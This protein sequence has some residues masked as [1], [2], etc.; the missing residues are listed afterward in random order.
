M[1]TNED[2]EEFYTGHYGL[3]RSIVR[4]YVRNDDID[5]CV[6]EAMLRTWK[7]YHT[8]Q[9]KRKI[10][11][12]AYSIFRNTAINYAKSLSYR[13]VNDSE[14]LYELD[15]EEEAIYCEQE[16]YDWYEQAER[17]LSKEEPEV[18]NVSMM[19]IAGHT[20]CDIEK[21]LD[22]DKKDIYDYWKRGKEVLIKLLE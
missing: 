1:N 12:W 6:Q 21:T 16:Y 13:N 10:F 9:D 8:L 11:F 14:Y 15:E 5:D 7:Y 22:I 20:Y 2:F 17:A 3:A 19:K 4:K 18:Y